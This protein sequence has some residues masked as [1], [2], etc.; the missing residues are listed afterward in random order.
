MIRNPENKTIK[1]GTTLIFSHGEY[2]DY[3][4]SGVY[5]CIKDFDY[6]E[7]A[8]KFYFEEMNRQYEENPKGDCCVFENADFDRYLINKGFLI[9]LNPTEIHT[10]DYYFFD[11]SWKD[12]FYNQ[13]TKGL[14]ND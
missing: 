13:K 14:N 1:A 10:G 12:E 9:L 7:E 8:K 11:D 5:I 4:L 2:D 6:I 3:T